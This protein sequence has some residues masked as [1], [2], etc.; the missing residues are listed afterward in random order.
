MQWEKYSMREWG[1]SKECH[2][3]NLF[4]FLNNLENQ[5]LLESEIAKLKETLNE[6]EKAEKN[7]KLMQQINEME[8]IIST[9]EK[10][11][12]DLKWEKKRIE[13]L[14]T[15]VVLQNHELEKQQKENI[16]LIDEARHSVASYR[17]KE[18]EYPFLFSFYSISCEKQHPATDTSSL[19]F[20]NLVN[21]L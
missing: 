3:L 14:M 18:E 12:L 5:F 7:Q 9:Q 8:N 17:Q 11:I 21:R 20:L 15:E 2:S 19:L 16:Q 1:R 6:K 13:E 4:I 10:Q